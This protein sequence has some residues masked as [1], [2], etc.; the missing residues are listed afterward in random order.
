MEYQ[1][2]RVNGAFEWEN[3]PALS[4]AKVLWTEDAGIRAQAQLACDEENLYVHLSACE[5]EIRAEYTQP[6]SPVYE[7]SCLEFF[8]QQPDCGNYFNFEINPEGCLRI[9]Y[10]PE[11]AG[12]IDIVRGDGAAYFDIRTGRTPEGWEVFYKI[13]LSF[14]Q[15]FRPDWR[16]AGVMRANFYKCGDRTAT[17]HY[18][19]WA[20]VDT[21]QPDFHRPEFFGTLRF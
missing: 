5:K 13:P 19:A 20:P 15:L 7:D 12:R 10:G 8:F 18:L 16:F 1:L 11:R 4:I 6:L 2:T 3:I 14:L 21:A 17:A 9:Q